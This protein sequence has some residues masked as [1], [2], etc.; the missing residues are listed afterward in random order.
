MLHAILKRL[1]GSKN[2]RELKRISL[3][4]NEITDLEP[5]MIAASDEA[6]RMK[7][8]YFREKLQKGTELDDILVEAFAVVREASR[9]T[10][11]RSSAGWSSMRGK[12]PR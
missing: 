2:D 8:L 3:L 7:T 12:S 11:H 1:V 10:L 4:L 6:L 5:V 9:R